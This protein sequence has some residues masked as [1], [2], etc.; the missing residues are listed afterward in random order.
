MRLKE[1]TNSVRFD[2]AGEPVFQEMV[3]H[4]CLIR[5]K[6][7]RCDPTSSGKGVFFERR[8]PLFGFASSIRFGE[9]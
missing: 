6:K 9:G 4:L 8:S 7:R 1:F 5:A 3:P 2:A